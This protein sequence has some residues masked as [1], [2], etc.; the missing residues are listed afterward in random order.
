MS[1]QNVNIFFWFVYL[2]ERLKHPVRNVLLNLHMPG[3]I[4]KPLFSVLLLL[5]EHLLL[6]CVT[7]NLSNRLHQINMSSRPLEPLMPQKLWWLQCQIIIGK[8]LHGRE[9]LSLPE[10]ETFSMLQKSHVLDFK[11][12]L[13]CVAECLPHS[14]HAF[15]GSC[16]LFLYSFV[17]FSG[18]HECHPEGTHKTTRSL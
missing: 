7:F 3:L 2:C 15:P 14:D 13:M 9:I 12:C 11:V 18:C 16:A 5:S 17:V 6:C 4:R 1:H 10:K 8:I